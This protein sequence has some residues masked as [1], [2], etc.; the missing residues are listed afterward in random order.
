MARCFRPRN[1]FRWSVVV[2]GSGSSGTVSGGSRAIR[3]SL[4]TKVNVG[5]GILLAIVNV[6]GYGRGE[7]G[8]TL[9]LEDNKYKSTV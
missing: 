4:L 1:S 7:I 9:P 2:W 8:K 5:Y 3:L 6:E